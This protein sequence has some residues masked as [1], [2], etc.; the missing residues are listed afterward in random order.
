M[1]GAP[2]Y[3]T[4]KEVKYAAYSGK[5]VMLGGRRVIIKSIKEKIVMQEF[6]YE[7]SWYSL[8]VDHFE[9]ES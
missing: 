5:R 6:I 1:L 2:K 9:M 3:A 7:G 8:P 4:V